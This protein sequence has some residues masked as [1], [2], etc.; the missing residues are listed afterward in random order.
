MIFSPGDIVRLKSTRRGEDML[1]DSKPRPD[2]GIICKWQSE[3][4]WDCACFDA[5]H[6]EIVK[7]AEFKEVTP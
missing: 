1:V 5:S 3:G 2:G 4:L 7:S 6:L